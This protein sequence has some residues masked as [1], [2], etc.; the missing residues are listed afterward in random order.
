[1][2][3]R[4]RS[5]KTSVVAALFSG[6]EPAS[7]LHG[8]ILAAKCKVMGVSGGKGAGWWGETLLHHWLGGSFL[9]DKL[10]WDRNLKLAALG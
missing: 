10:V 9:Q 8:R 3:K 1:M 5:P 6:G 2:G 4:L 7:L